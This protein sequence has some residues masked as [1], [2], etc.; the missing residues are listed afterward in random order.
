MKQKEG[1]KNP[2]LRKIVCDSSQQAGM[3]IFFTRVSN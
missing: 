2:D 3:F 1:E